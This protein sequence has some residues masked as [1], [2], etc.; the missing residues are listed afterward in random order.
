M[1]KIEINPTGLTANSEVESN[2]HAWL[3]FIPVANPKIRKPT[4]VI[5]FKGL[6]VEDCT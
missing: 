2:V 6:Q 5:V 3:D 1:V 4:V